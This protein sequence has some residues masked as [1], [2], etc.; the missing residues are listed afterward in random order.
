MTVYGDAGMGKSRLIYEFL[1]GAET[2]Q[3]AFLQSDNIL[4]IS[5]NPFK[6][7]LNNYFHQLESKKE[8]QKKHKF[9]LIFETLLAEL[10]RLDDLRAK[11]ILS[12]LNRSKSIL[13][14]QV[15]IHYKDSLYEKLDAR[16]RYENTLFA[17]K[18][19]FKAL[20]LIKPI[21]I[22]VEDI[23]WLDDDSQKVF[24]T[25]CRNIN[26]FP[27]MIIAS[28]R[29]N[30]DGSK[31]RIQTEKSELQH[32]LFLSKLEKV[33][34]I[35][36]IETQLEGKASDSLIEQ[37]GSR[38]EYN[39]FYIEQIISYLKENRLLRTEHNE[40]YILE[41]ET[42]IPGSITAIIIA[43][44]DRLENELKNIVQIASVLGREVE[45]QLLLALL[46]V[47]ESGQHKKEIYSYIKK[48]EKDQIWSN[49]LEI[50]YIFKHALLH[51]AIYE[52]QLKARIR[53][54]HEKAAHSIIMIYGETEEKYY[55][56]ASHFDKAEMAGKAAE[57]YLKA[58][59]YHQ[60]IITIPRR[61]NALNVI[62]LLQK[63]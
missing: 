62:S 46:E 32:E 42:E 26:E 1:K 59:D 28:S 60:K 57:F 53:E 31:P 36:F 9:E 7:Y 4:Q 21:L 56:I 49:L 52:M 11:E 43:R 5:M 30:D 23:Q 17:Y 25:L 63:Y 29:F 48:I 45:L 16:G 40:F 6:Y 2:F 8:E 34:A 58:G 20:S 22:Q 50:K 51:E 61:W 3:S 44:I 55:E 41:T 54:L 15:E 13:A 18:A 12:E 38:T 47:Y 39:P 10:G 14:A 24:Q 33:A 37:I 19:L 35:S 27:I